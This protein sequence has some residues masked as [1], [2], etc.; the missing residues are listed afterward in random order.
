MTSWQTVPEFLSAHRG[1]ISR[2][3][4]YERIKDGPA[5]IHSVRPEILS[6]SLFPSH[7][8]DRLFEQA[9]TRASST[10]RSLDK[11]RS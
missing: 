8:F 3:E 2:S 6:K 7:A 4:L 1:R 10:G 5:T 11:G 9:G